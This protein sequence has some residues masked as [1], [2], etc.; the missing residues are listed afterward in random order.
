MR[1]FLYSLLLLL[2]YG[3]RCCC[4]YSVNAFWFVIRAYRHIYIVRTLHL[5]DFTMNSILSW[6]TFNNSNGKVQP[7]NMQTRMA[8]VN[9]SG[10][11]QRHDKRT[12]PDQWDAMCN[13]ILEFFDSFSAGNWYFIFTQHLSG[14]WII[15]IFLFRSFWIPNSIRRGLGDERRIC[16]RSPFRIRTRAF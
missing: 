11:S 6:S 9:F 5:S 10:Q 14:A 4:C 15:A 7:F 13:W 12:P 8:I 2:P 16:F 3:C 1:A